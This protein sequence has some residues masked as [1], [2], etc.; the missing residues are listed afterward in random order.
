MKFAPVGRWSVDSLTCGPYPE[1]HPLPLGNPYETRP[2]AV[3]SDGSQP[4]FTLTIDGVDVDVV[5]GGRT[6]LDVL[7]GCGALS[8][9]DGCSPQGQCGCCTV[10]VDGAPR[11]SCVTPAKRV[12]GR[13]IAT[14]DGLE[15]QRQQAWADALTSTGGSQ[16]GFCTPGIICR[17]EGAAI[18]GADLA[19]RALV[20]KA[21]LG[22]LCRCTGWQTIREAAVVIASGVPSTKGQTGRD[23]AAAAERASIEGGAP[24]MVGPDVALGRGGFAADTAPGDAL[25]AVPN[26]D[27]WSVAP[28]LATARTLAGKVQG[29]RTTVAAEPAIAV[30]AGDWHVVLSTCWTEPAYLET[31]V[32]WCEPGGEP[33][34][35]LANGGA[36]GAKSDDLLRGVA[37]R[38]AD[39]HQSAV[40]VVLDREDVVRLG[41]KRPPVAIGADSSGRGVIHVARTPGVA[42][43]LAEIA[44]EFEVV[45]I[46]VVGPPT[47]L[48]VRAAVRAEIEMVRHALRPQGP[49][50]VEI[51]DAWAEATVDESGVHVRLQ[52]G[53]VLD[54]VVLRSYAIGAAH[55][56]LSFVR[57]ESI[58]VDGTGT[59]HDLTIRSFGVLRSMDTPE[60]TIDIVESQGPACEVSTAVFCA[61][62]AAAW[63]LAATPPILP[64]LAN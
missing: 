21:L 44:P 38:L 13:S 62:A 14:V 64:V 33:V 16:C 35:P 41:P 37:R 32:V 57:S 2:P 36:F 52:A 11:V 26:A 30:P 45:E 31:D 46:D 51:G 43:L 59:V 7:R 50:R 48:D 60:I 3:L 27:E 15:P 63:R 12:R 47:S 58:A 4:E 28:D 17:L 40:R 25:V 10:L 19:D 22:H 39:E 56:G 6:L 42:E 9:K 29:R 24:Q 18:K 61:V 1:R 55:Q 5:D 53:A 20:D 49:A 34:G 8:V 54:H 23:L